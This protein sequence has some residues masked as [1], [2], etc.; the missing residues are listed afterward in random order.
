[1]LSIC[2]PKSSE[3]WDEVPASVTAFLC[4]RNILSPEQRASLLR[5]GADIRAI[6]NAPPRKP[7]DYVSQ[8][9]SRLEAAGFFD[10]SHLIKHF[11][12]FL[13]ISPKDYVKACNTP[14]T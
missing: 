3:D 13:G 12:H 1:M 11:R 10:Q 5:A 4:S 9:R 2:I 8:I 7:V 14:L 6:K